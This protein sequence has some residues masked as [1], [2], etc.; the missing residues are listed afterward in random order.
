MMTWVAYL[1]SVAGSDSTHSVAVLNHHHVAYL[2]DPKA[3][4]KDLADDGTMDL[5]FDYELGD[6]PDV[7]RDR[8]L[9]GRET[10]AVQ[11]FAALGD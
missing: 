1:G 2:E 10:C 7:P 4:L 6:D 8:L 5:Y 11:D 9:G 3:R